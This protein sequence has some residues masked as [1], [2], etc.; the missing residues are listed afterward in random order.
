MIYFKEL[1]A[2]N[3]EF[4]NDWYKTDNKKIKTIAFWDNTL[5]INEIS[6]N[7]KKEGKEIIK[8]GFGQSPFQV[9]EKVVEELK[10]NAHQN[11][12]LPMQGL[13]ELRES[14]AKYTT[15]KK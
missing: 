10:K 15:N 6:K 4:P 7:I 11:Q 14:V 1:L 2:A 9:P 13:K 3:F 5:K 8:F 12:Y